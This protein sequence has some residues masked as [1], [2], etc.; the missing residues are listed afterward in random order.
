MS[1]GILEMV[2]SVAVLIFAIPA[3]LAGVDLFLA[4]NT[5][6]GVGLVGAALAMVVAEKYVVR[7]SDLPTLLAEKLVGAVAR[8]P[9]EE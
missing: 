2:G 1:W 6:L 8:P 9:D 7:P 4:G 3:A 5:L